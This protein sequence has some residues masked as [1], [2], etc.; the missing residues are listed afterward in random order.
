MSAHLSCAR[1]MKL[2]LKLPLKPKLKLT[3]QQREKRG[4]DAESAAALWLR[5]KGYRILDRRVKTPRGEI[6]LIASKGKMLIFVEVKAREEMG[7]ALEA[8]T[9]DLQRRVQ[10]AANIWV[11]RKPKLANWL[12]RFDIVLIAPGGVPRHMR[13]AW[14]A[15]APR[16]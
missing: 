3:R 8:V 16:T 13:D 14:R 10:D 2:D 12:W 15:E 6:D 1:Q 5:L 7:K 11:S 4:R 9:P